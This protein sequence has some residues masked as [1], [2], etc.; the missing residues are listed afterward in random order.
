M[1][2]N[3][4]PLPAQ[5]SKQQ[6]VKNR[7][8][9]ERMPEN[10]RD[11]APFYADL[12]ES[13][14][15]RSLKNLSDFAI[16]TA[17]LADTKSCVP[18]LKKVDETLGGL[19]ISKAAAL[20]AGG[21]RL[22]LSECILQMAAAGGFNPMQGVVLTG[23]AG[24]AFS[25]IT[26]NKIL[27]KDGLS[28]THGEFTHSIQWLMIIEAH[29]QLGLRTPKNKIAD[30]YSQAGTTSTQK[31]YTLTGEKAGG[32]G[33][34]QLKSG[35]FD[36]VC[37]AFVPK[38]ADSD[39]T[40]LLHN[41]FT[42]SARS[43][44]FITKLIEGAELPFLYDYYFGALGKYNDTKRNNLQEYRQE[45]ADDKAAAGTLKQIGSD[46]AYAPPG[47]YDLPDPIK[48]GKLI[49]ERFDPNYKRK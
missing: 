18:Y 14:F 1:N 12:L 46:K 32:K 42:K 23:D 20:A 30:L 22:K 15:G 36:F 3:P 44:A 28:R 21:A 29:P 33:D 37:D 43:P 5:K 48:S 25:M 9:S 10:W 19:Y 35:L 31:G 2:A 34:R 8:D 11:A 26:G 47:F 16:I 13:L 39:Q 7:F 41:L 24:T 4:Y 27:F 17:F 6:E 38:A 40:F 45:K 49:G